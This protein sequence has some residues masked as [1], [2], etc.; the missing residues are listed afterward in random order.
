MFSLD[1]F[2]SKV[3][4]PT[5]VSE[6]KNYI[7][8]EIDELHALMCEIVLEKFKNFFTVLMHNKIS[9]LDDVTR[10]REIHNLKPI[11]VYI[12]K[13]V[14]MSFNAYDWFKIMY[15]FFWVAANT[16]PPFSATGVTKTLRRR[17]MRNP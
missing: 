2:L 17:A 6:L 3:N 4:K 16:P 10:F 12:C 14:F 5:T 11:H 8:H 7:R 1:F 9:I 15:P 13:T